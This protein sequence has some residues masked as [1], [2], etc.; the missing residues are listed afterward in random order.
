MKAI[1]KV[2][3]IFK[4][5]GKIGSGVILCLAMC[6][7]TT[8]AQTPNV[9]LNWGAS[10][11]P[12]ILSYNILRAPCTGTVTGTTCSV[13]P[14]A[15]AFT[16]LNS[17]PITVLTYTDNTVDITPPT[18]SSLSINSGAVGSTVTITGSGFGASQGA[19]SVTFNGTAATV[20]S[21]SATSIVVVVPVGATTGNLVVNTTNGGFA[22]VYTITDSC[23]PT[24]CLSGSVVVATG[25]SAFSNELTGAATIVS[26]ASSLFTVTAAP[27]P[28][29]PT[30]TI[31]VNP[32]ASISTPEPVGTVYN[33][34]CSTN[35]G[36]VALVNG[37]PFSSTSYLLQAVPSGQSVTCAATAIAPSGVSSGTGPSTTLT[38]S[39]N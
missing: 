29:A 32:V 26:S 16:A 31:G 19:G 25:T 28:I 27:A 23:P 9:T 36:P 33:L 39:N 10:P 14:P 5:V 12:G 37:T 17:V 6:A 15:A 2:T 24:G 7:A 13:V 38:V 18:I 20:T 11:T 34:L 3:K 35:G 1:N 4:A 21:W 30:L 8:N 22:Y